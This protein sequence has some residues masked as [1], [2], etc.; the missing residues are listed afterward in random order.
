MHYIVCLCFFRESLIKFPDLY[1]SSI[2]QAITD[3]LKAKTPNQVN[4]CF[5]QNGKICLTDWISWSSFVRYQGRP[6]KAERPTRLHH[7]L[8]LSA[9]KTSQV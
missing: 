1:Y 9:K 3:T 6:L 7:K 2:Q 4:I 5:A 8:A